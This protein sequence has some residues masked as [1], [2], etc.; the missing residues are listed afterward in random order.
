MNNLSSIKS[1]NIVL[2]LCIE[3]SKNIKKVVTELDIQCFYDDTN[4]KIFFALKSIAKRTYNVDITLLIIEL[5]KLKLL[6]EAIGFAKIS[7]I[8]DLA[9]N[10]N[11]LDE[12]ISI[13][14]E[15]KNIR[16]L[17]ILMLESSDAIDK[18]INHIDIIDN[19][20]RAFVDIES[21]SD[22]G[23]L[24]DDVKL[25]SEYEKI[26][27]LN[28]EN[29]EKFGEDYIPGIET[30]FKKLDRITGG[31]MKG[32]LI[33]LAAASGLG[34]TTFAFNMACNMS[35]RSGN[36]GAIISLE[37]SNNE[38]FAKVMS[39]F[40]STCYDDIQKGRDKTFKDFDLD[41]VKDR[42]SK[43]KLVF[44]DKG[45][46]KISDL[47]S[48]VR[49]EKEVNGLDFVVIDYIQL[50]RA[51]ETRDLRHL[52]VGEVSGKLKDLAKELRIPI[53]ALA[54]L[55]RKVY[56]RPDNKPKLSDLR[57]SG[58]LEQD[59]DIVIMLNRK[60]YHNVES[61]SKTLDVYVNK[62]RHGDQGYVQMMSEKGGSIIKELEKTVQEQVYETINS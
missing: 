32:N 19:L 7:G 41:K 6:E 24:V 61:E 52:E 43:G 1:E 31:L 14:R 29:R 47:C 18:N 57:E 20:R 34:K 33:I 56:D 54:Q 27:R 16:K 4:K 10:Y 9:L 39:S 11:N 2:S 15:K 22:I 8:Q 50:V 23:N 59:A 40:N 48:I 51:S 46:L 60:S 44:H 55:S 35:Y 26:G 62:N 49:R 3:N 13:L 53:L 17:N 42:M 36:R 21:E 25:L 12:H 28:L 30:G 37:M 38:C 45:G 58:K 5:K